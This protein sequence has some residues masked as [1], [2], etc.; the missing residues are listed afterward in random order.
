MT[1]LS[2]SPSIARKELAERFE[3]NLKMLSLLN[4][5][6]DS[7][8]VVLSA[9]IEGKRLTSSGNSVPADYEVTRLS[10]IIETLEKKYLFPIQHLNVSVR[11]VTTGRMT[12]QTIYLIESEIVER[13]IEDSDSVFANQ[14]RE[15]FFR[16]I[17]K[18]NKYFQKLIE[19]KGSLSNAVL[20]LIHHAYKDKPL[21]QEAWREMD[22]KFLSMLDKLNVA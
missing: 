13:L 7:Q 3:T 18:E 21:S 8:V 5:M 11:S 2:V 22:N 4:S 10:A 19:K 6:Q 17:A 14:E 16:G 12:T 20:S 1:A 9:L 15:L